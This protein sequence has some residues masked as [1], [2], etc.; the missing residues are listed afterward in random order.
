[1]PTL[2]PSTTGKKAGPANACS[3]CALA[4]KQVGRHHVG[5]ALDAA[6]HDLSP[7]HLGHLEAHPIADGYETEV[8]VPA[9]DVQNV[10]A[11]G[12]ALE[13]QPSLF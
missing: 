11:I 8:A 13:V 2:A 3:T 5:N 4:G 12:L 7:E 10:A 6:P 1:M 9:G